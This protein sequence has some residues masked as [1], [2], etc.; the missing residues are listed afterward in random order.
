[1]SAERNELIE[2]LRTSP[3]PLFHAEDILEASGGDFS[4]NNDPL[5]FI[6]P[7]LLNFRA[8]VEAVDVAASFYAGL[9]P[10]DET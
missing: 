3:D 6:R 7:Y 1:M 10:I 2:L 5:V 8:L 9:A 4:V